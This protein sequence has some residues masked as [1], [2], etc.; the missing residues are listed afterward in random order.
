MRIK[1]I[2]GALAALG[3]TAC[4]TTDTERALTGAVAGGLVAEV[5]DENVVAGAAAG[6]LI[7]ALSCDLVPNAPN[8]F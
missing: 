3:L 4:G 7:G 1:I 5:A 2:A 8:C 6:G